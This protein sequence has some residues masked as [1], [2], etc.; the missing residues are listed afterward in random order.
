MSVFTRLFA[1]LFLMICCAC[2]TYHYVPLNYSPTDRNNEVIETQ[3]QPEAYFENELFRINVVYIT[4]T[5]EK[6][7]YGVMVENTSEFAL[8][9]QPKNMYLEL[10]NHADT[11]YRRIRAINPEDLVA[12]LHTEMENN[13]RRMRSANTLEA[14]T[15]GAT[16]AWGLV[17]IL[18]GETWEENQTREALSMAAQVGTT[19]N[20]DSKAHKLEQSERNYRNVINKVLQPGYLKPGQYIMGEVSFPTARPS[21]Q[22]NVCIPIHGDTTKLEFKRS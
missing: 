10:K 15:Y 1:L 7:T 2:G 21:A 14:V 19:L 20:A 8:R 16:L 12:D 22:L 3:Q 4:S 11:V 6:L 5:E 13:H 17:S 18:S 9:V